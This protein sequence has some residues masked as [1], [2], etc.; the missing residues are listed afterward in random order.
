MKTFLFVGGPL[1]GQEIELSG[2]ASYILDGGF[3]RIAG[4]QY[5]WNFPGLHLT[6]LTAA[7]IA[8]QETSIFGTHE[9][10]RFTRPRPS[11]LPGRSR[12]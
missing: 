9:R 4:N 2:A 10:N 3:Y 11:P 6:F 7:F 8:S 5:I 12:A 1:N